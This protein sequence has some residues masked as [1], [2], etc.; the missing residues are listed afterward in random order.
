ML[1]FIAEPNRKITQSTEQTLIL[2]VET[3]FQDY[4][5]NLTLKKTVMSHILIPNLNK[6]A[7]D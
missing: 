5:I 1:S 7:F 4:D 3:I 6:L 2:S